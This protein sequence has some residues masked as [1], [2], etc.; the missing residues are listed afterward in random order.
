MLGC[1]VQL[2]LDKSIRLPLDIVRTMTEQGL[3]DDE[4][5]GEAQIKE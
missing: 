1:Y 5:E 3:I 4:W 2:E